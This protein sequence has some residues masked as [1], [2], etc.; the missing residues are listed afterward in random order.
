M[1][2]KLYQ[3][4]NMLQ[5]GAIALYVLPNGPFKGETRPCI[6]TQI[7]NQEPE[8]QYFGMSNIVVF[9]GQLADGRGDGYTFGVGSV[10]FDPEKKPGTWH[11]ADDDE[12]IPCG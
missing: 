3:S 10:A 9:K 8:G 5:Q 7:W 2:R 11:F 6:L 4:A 1:A 12:V